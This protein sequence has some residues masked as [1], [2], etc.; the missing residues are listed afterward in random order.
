MPHTTNQNQHQQQR[1][2]ARSLSWDPNHH[3]ALRNS[4]KICQ[5]R[6]KARTSSILDLR[7]RMVET[8]WSEGA[9]WKD[10]LCA[11][12]NV[13]SLRHY[14][15]ISSSFYHHFF[16]LFVLDPPQQIG[17][18]KH[19][20][21]IY[22]QS[23]TPKSSVS[24]LRLSSACS[25]S[26]IFLY[27]TGVKQWDCHAC[28]CWRKGAHI[29]FHGAVRAGSEVRGGALVLFEAGYGPYHFSLG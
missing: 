23:C 16:L 27:E 8:A 3:N 2:N 13:I 5:C 12:H 21:V 7:W 9:Y 25:L 14:P 22:S 29:S 4:I 28:A 26:H 15:V 18:H 24:C 6:R 17:I 1:I 11:I 10:G 20:V 19:H